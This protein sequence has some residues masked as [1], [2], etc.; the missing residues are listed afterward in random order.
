MTRKSKEKR[1]V[2]NSLSHLMIRF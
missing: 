1:H 2:N